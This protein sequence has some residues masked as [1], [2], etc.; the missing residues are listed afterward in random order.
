VGGSLTK[1]GA[2]TLTLSGAN[3]YTGGTMIAGGILLINNTSGSGTGSDAVSVN[4]GGTLAGTGTIGG[5]LTVDSGGLVMLSGGALTVNGAVTN[6]GTMR[7]KRGASF[8]VGNGATFINNGTVDIITGSFAAPSGF[9]NNAVVLDSRLN[10]IKAIS[11][12]ASTAPASV[13]LTIESYTA[14]TYQLER[15]SAPK[16]GTFLPLAGV[17]IQN[18]TT[19]LTLTFI[20]PAAPAGRGF[21]RIAVDP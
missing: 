14:H 3:T 20:D 13:T 8:V 12:N 17:P 1:E 11:R 9:T 10:K 21:Y 19:G 2:G 4:N 16:S 5:P 15:S 18:G 7:F 6:N